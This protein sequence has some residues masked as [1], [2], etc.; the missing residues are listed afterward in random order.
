MMGPRKRAVNKYINYRLV[1]RS[2]FQDGEATHRVVASRRRS[3]YE[4]LPCQHRMN[5]VRNA[6]PECAAAFKVR[7]NRV[8]LKRNNKMGRRAEERK[9][10]AEAFK[11]HLKSATQ[12]YP[13]AT[14]S[15]AFCLVARTGRGARQSRSSE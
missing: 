11:W 9:D 7:R 8:T 3:T 15:V 14:S 12:G 2:W 6:D 13:Y 4:T 1:A 5:F 10:Y